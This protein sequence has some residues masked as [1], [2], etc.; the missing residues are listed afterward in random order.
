MLGAPARICPGFMV[1]QFSDSQFSL[2]DFYL[3]DS[4][5]PV[6]PP[7]DYTRWRR[8]FGRAT[9]LYEQSLLGAPVARTTLQVDGKP[10]S[11]VNL[12][13]YNYLGLATHPETVAAAHRALDTYGTGAC[14]SPMLS[15]MTDQHRQL[16]NDL[17][18]FLDREATMLFN[19]GFGGALG[20]LAGLLRRGDVAV[21]DSRCHISLLDGATL[22]Q[23]QLRTFEHNDPASLDAQ[24]ER[25]RGRRQLVVVEGIYSMD[26]DL[27]ELPVLLEVAE[28]HRVGVLIDE[29]HSILTCGPHG[30]G[31][32]EHF[33]VDN[34]V[35]LKYGTFSKA[36]AGVGGFVS[37]PSTTLDYLR[38]FA[39]PYG[40]SCALPPMVVA[41]LIAG[42]DVATRDETL[43]QR[44][45]ANAAYFRRGLHALGIG[46]GESV[47]QVI[48]I[49]VGDNRDLLYELGHAMLDR[50]LFL[51]PVDYP[52][53]PQDRL[54]FRASITAVHTRADLDEALNVLEDTLAGRVPGIEA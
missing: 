41:A 30:K 36:F 23:A 27:A 50:G 2:A 4:D 7:E 18:G 17:S 22:S 32:T 28:H 54:R 12:S 48:P 19:S 21:V 1:M 38:A 37:G 5:D 45:W 9:A 29:A 8:E 53:V 52:S 25:G 47:S 51:A 16:E 42:L 3:S 33:G 43:R 11:I 46:T 34:R 39:H 40:F 35:V 13:S 24:L 6:V 15:G 26:G 31:A 10:R 49:I 14:G 20:S 44:M